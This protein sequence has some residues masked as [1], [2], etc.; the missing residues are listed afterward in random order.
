LTGLSNT[1]ELEFVTGKV[2]HELWSNRT[3]LLKEKRPGIFISKI[4]LEKVF[5][6]LKRQG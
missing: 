3:T 4:L 2:I 1:D 6:H 5:S